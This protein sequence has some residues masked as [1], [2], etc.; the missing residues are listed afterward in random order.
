[1]VKVEPT[2][3]SD[4][5]PSNAE[6]LTA[7]QG[8]WGQQ[9]SLL[10]GIESRLGAKLETGLASVKTELEAKIEAT[11]NQLHEEIAQEIQDRPVVVHVDMGRVR[12]L[13]K[14]V[15]SLPIACPIS[16]TAHAR[17]WATRA[18]LRSFRFDFLRAL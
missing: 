6:L 10:E 13:E 16:R 4:R 11:A 8:M 12:E 7:M 1:M 9:K 14:Q 3:D 18:H 5:G 2:S 15:Q 17:R